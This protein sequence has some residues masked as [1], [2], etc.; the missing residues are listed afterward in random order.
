MAHQLLNKVSV[1]AMYMKGLKRPKQKNVEP[2]CGLKAK[3]T[4][5]PNPTATYLTTRKFNL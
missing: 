1:K 3:I 4:Q 2:G 5:Y